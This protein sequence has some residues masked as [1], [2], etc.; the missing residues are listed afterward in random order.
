MGRGSI[1][2]VGHDGQAGEG[3]WVWVWAGGSAMRRVV[4]EGRH[5]V[6]SMKLLVCR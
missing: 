1:T 3:L 6:V 5:V 2:R 4:V